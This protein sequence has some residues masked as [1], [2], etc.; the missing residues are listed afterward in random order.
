MMCKF[1]VLVAIMLVIVG[2]ASAF[3]S[4]SPPSLSLLN[5]FD[6]DFNSMIN[7]M[8]APPRNRFSTSRS[9]SRVPSLLDKDFILTPPS[10]RFIVR[11]EYVKPPFRVNVVEQETGGIVEVTADLP[12]IRKEDV[13][14][15][16]KDGSLIINVEKTESPLTTKCEESASENNNESE[17]KMEKVKA[18][19]DIATDSS[20]SSPTEEKI[21]RSAAGSSSCSPSNVVWLEERTSYLG[22]RTIQLPMNVDEDNI[23][24]H[25]ESGVLKI[26]I[27]RVTSVEP[28][29]KMV[30]IK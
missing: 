8:L 6:D 10:T 17:E 27:P 7:T 13:Q 25:L 18:K 24:A 26:S 30:Q 1:A 20:S 15:E 12:G 19:A 3:R 2:N 22:S 23:S 29:K 16:I 21:S 5:M 11:S 14:I 9:R 4:Y 28:K